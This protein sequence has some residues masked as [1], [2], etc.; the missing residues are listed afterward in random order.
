MSK[1]Q[2]AHPADLL[3]I[4]VE[5]AQAPAQRLLDR[6]GQLLAVAM[7]SSSTD[8]VS[9]ADQASERAL[10]DLLTSRRPD[11]GLL[12]EEGAARPSRTGLRWVIDPL[13]G[14]VNYL[15]GLA[16]WSVSVAVESHDGSRWRAVAGAVLQPS[17]GELYTAARDHGAHLGTCDNPEEVELAVNDPVDLPHA[18]IATGFSYDR[19]HRRKQAA[20]AAGVVVA[21]RD[22]RRMGS[23]ALD[24]CAVASGRVDGFYE[25]SLHRWDWA[26][27]GLIAGE[28]GAVVAPLAGGLSGQEG[29]IAS[30][31]ALYP[32]LRALLDREAV[33]AE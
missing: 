16:S 28:A 31:P 13:D 11:D 21:T 4:A 15:Y 27:G 9:E 32:D 18:L 8:P 2:Y 1:A 24:L 20:T 10:V 3:A 17:S 25:D 5:A 6:Q 22:L 14:T 7:K 33:V 12:G 23:A 29:V 30:G 19:E 26:A